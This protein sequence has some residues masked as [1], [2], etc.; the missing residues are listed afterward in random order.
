MRGTT[1]SEGRADE[2]DQVTEAVRV[3]PLVVVPADDLDLVADDLGQ[4]SV[5]DARGGVGDDVGGHDRV[6]RVLEELAVGGS[7]DDLVD[8]LDGGLATGLEGQVGGRAGRDRDPESEAVELA[9]ELREHQADR[10]G[11]TGAGG[12]DVQRGGTRSA[13]VAVDVV[14]QVL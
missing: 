9:L 10:L 8:L 3:A 11:S 13:Q 4:R 12:D 7:L 1:S 14:L 2:G 6:G 5:E